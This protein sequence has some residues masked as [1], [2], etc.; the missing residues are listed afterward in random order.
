MWKNET[1]TSF[2]QHV[3][4]NPKIYYWNFRKKK[5]TWRVNGTTHAKFIVCLFRW[6]LL[7]QRF[8]FNHVVEFQINSPKD[9]CVELAKI[10]FSQ[11]LSSLRQRIFFYLIFL[12]KF[13][14][15]GTEAVNSG[16]LDICYRKKIKKR[17]IIH[18]YL[19]CWVLLVYLRFL[20]Q[21]R[22]LASWKR[23]HQVLSSKRKV[24][25]LL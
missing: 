15:K 23:G 19:S 20:S 14:D 10:I 11:K 16:F 4:F 9:S 7:N 8:Y 3:F 2:L 6:I 17:V 24:F 13:L 1:G 12:V 22:C 18:A 5:K 25:F 21:R